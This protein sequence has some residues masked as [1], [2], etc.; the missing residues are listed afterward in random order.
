MSEYGL[1][2][3]SRSS[4]ESLKLTTAYGEEIFIH[5]HSFQGQQCKVS[6]DAALDT[7][8]VRTESIENPSHIVVED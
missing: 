7:E 5:F 8:V 2:T 4:G 3:V 1:L 6:I